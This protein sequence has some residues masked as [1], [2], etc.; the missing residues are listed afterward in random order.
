VISTYQAL[1]VALLAILPGASYTFAVERT[2]GSYGVNLADRLIRFLAASAVFHAFASGL[3]LTLYRRYVVPTKP[4]NGVPW[5]GLELLAIAYVFVPIGVG[6]L[7]GAARRNKWWIGRLIVGERNE[8]RA[9]DWLWDKE[10]AL[11][12]VKL[13][14]GTWVAGVYATTA[15]R[16]SYASSYP[17]DDSD[18]YLSYA[19]VTDPHTGAL[20]PD[21]DGTAMKPDGEPGLLLRWAEI[22]YLEFQ[23][24][25]DDS[26]RGTGRREPGD[27][28][29]AGRTHERQADHQ[30]AE[31]DDASCG[32][33]AG[34]DASDPAHPDARAAEND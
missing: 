4:L 1:L 26:E 7:L 33:S 20:T 27:D 14:S 10:S 31:G 9:W 22:E 15:E 21:E 17:V 3:E 16:R 5:W 8:P 13:K 32:R 30:D 23:E 28:R 25:D 12:R 24:F 2:I 11:V 6:F 29:E 19:L 34:G 18:L